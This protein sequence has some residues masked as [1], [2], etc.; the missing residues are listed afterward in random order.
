MLSALK[1]HESKDEQ[2]ILQPG[3][4]FLALKVLGDMFSH[5]APCP[6]S[7]CDWHGSHKALCTTMLQYHGDP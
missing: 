6:N 4:W 2:L 1:I 3:W 7:V 5:Q